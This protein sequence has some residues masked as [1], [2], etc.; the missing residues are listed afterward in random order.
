MRASQRPL[1]VFT[2][3]RLLRQLGAWGGVGAG[4]WLLAACGG[5][6]GQS[7]AAGSSAASTSALPTTAATTGAPTTS[8]ATSVSGTAS[9]PASVATSSPST[10]GNAATSTASASV[11]PPAQGAGTLSYWAFGGGAP[12]GDQLFR[13][14]A[15][16]YTKDSA[17]KVTV[18]YTD[19]SSDQIE[20]K[21]LTAWV[22][23]SGPD[24]LFDSSRG[25]LRFMDSDI[26]LDVAPDM[27][28][29]KL[30][31]SDWYQVSLDFFQVKGQQ[32]GMPQGFG[33]Q[34]YG[35][36]LD[37]LQKAGVTLAPGFDQ[38]WGQDEL[39]QMLKQVVRYAPSGMETPGG[40]DDSVLDNWL[41]N[42]GSDLVSADL[43]SSPAANAGGIDAATWYQQAHTGQR[44][45]MRPTIDYPA[46]V[47]FAAGNVAMT[48]NGAEPAVLS[49]WGSL[50]FKNNIYLRPKG[51]AD[52]LTRLYI[53]GFYVWN[54]TRVRD[55][56]VDFLFYLTNQG[57]T[58]MDNGGGY[59]IPAYRPVVE[60][61]F[62]PRPS[63]LNKQVW[64]TSAEH[65]RTD[66]RHP[67][68]IP[69]I[70]T[71]YGK[72][73]T[74]LRNGSMAPRDAMQAMAQEITVILQL[75]AKTPGYKRL[76]G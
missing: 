40:A 48:G 20:E 51:P 9:A 11:R 43:L 62:L 52:H 60:K 38:T 42:Y 68:W 67:K 63:S 65:S 45:F 50:P 39:L 15:D 4:F 35:L 16:N 53:D 10:A 36:N 41:W 28:Q 74:A 55:T 1:A 47:S 14:P 17:G 19:I 49:T 64:L 27:A 71:V 6:N 18:N 72:Y 7:T 58:Q 61:V 69:D 76:V 73:N 32:L 8:A 56:A 57:C 12:L 26:F 70:N 54:K 2:R 59:N 31:R 34:P 30:N 21:A 66:P 33:T 37:L 24:V 25:F 5:T 13:L 23:G 46:N 75:Y 3:R 29:R 44:V 22:S